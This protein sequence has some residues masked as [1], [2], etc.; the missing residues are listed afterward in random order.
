MA[1]TKRLVDSGKLP[2]YVTG[3]TIDHP[4]DPDIEHKANLVRR[5]ASLLKDRRDK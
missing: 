5:F 4:S 1:E 2:R 3:G